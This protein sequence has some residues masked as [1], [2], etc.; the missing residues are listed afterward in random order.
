MLKN[1]SENI[2]QGASKVSRR[3]DD[4]DVKSSTTNPANEQRRISKPQSQ[5]YPDALPSLSYQQ[6]D[7]VDLAKHFDATEETGRAVKVV[8]QA[9]A[10]S[11]NNAKVKARQLWGTDVYTCDSDVVAIIMHA[12]FYSHLL[13]NPPTSVSEAHVVVRTLPVQE[14]YPS[15][16]RNGIRSRSW[17][18]GLDGC[19][20]KVEGCWLVTKTGTAVELQPAPEGVPGIMPTFMPTASE[21]VMHTRSN[22]SSVERRQ[23]M[24]QEVTLQY[25]LCNEPWLKYTMGAV[26]DRGLQPSQWTSARLRGEV[27]F[28]ESHSARYEVSHVERAQS[29]DE[30]AE[31]DLFRWS[32]CKRNLSLAQMR[33]V[34]LPMPES[35]L[36]V[37]EPA[38]RWEDFQWC[39]SGVFVKGSHYPMVRVQFVRAM[40]PEGPK[41]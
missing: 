20:I 7:Q 4:A 38:L 18:G 32:R 23:R 33:K 10:L 39:P 36:E 1:S 15:R 8:V 19:S 28:L 14:R 22:A 21:R 29:A 11:K 2:E 6:N 27:L 25:N 13:A 3:G 37:L 31:E 26:A 41:D 24:K 12:G 5:V 34:G 16:W 35:M 40:Q 30:S 9:G 17:C